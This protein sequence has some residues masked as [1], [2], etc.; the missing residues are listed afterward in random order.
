MEAPRASLLRQHQR[1]PS[2]GLEQGQCSE[3]LCWHSKVH[4][5]PAHVSPGLRGTPGLTPNSPA[6][7]CP[8]QEPCEVDVRRSGYYSA[9][10]GDEDKCGKERR[11]IWQWVALVTRTQ[12]SVGVQMTLV[13]R[14]A[15]LGNAEVGRKSPFNR[16]FAGPLTGHR[17]HS[18][19]LRA[20]EA[21]VS[22]DLPK[23]TQLAHGTERLARL[24]NPLQ[25]LLFLFLLLVSTWCCSWRGGTWI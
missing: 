25:E 6:C 12:A 3:P 8:H 11:G 13:S 16:L 14:R 17:L 15:P 2:T 5:V 7:P 21:E 22:N 9:R 24:L 23:V 19:P 20:T 4:T 10:F 18:T 1:Q